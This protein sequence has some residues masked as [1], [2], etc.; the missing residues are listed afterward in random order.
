MQVLAPI[1][2]PS[3]PSTAVLWQWSVLEVEDD[4][5]S[6]VRLLAGVLDGTETRVRVTSQIEQIEGGQAITRSGSIYTLAGP[7]ATE[8]QTVAQASR[9]NAL[10]A[11]RQAEDV[12]HEYVKRW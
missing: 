5:G 7:P 6:R 9:R 11:G 8:E 10:L 12:T 1:G 4:D 2:Y 3:S